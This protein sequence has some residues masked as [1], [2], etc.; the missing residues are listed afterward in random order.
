M[1]M[2][3][4]FQTVKIEERETKQHGKSSS[5]IQLALRGGTIQFGLD[6]YFLMHIMKNRMW[7][8]RYWKIASFRSLIYVS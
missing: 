1:L 3:P 7:H 6:Q 4:L 8:S 2:E 5:I